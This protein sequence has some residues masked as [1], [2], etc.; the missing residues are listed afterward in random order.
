MCSKKPNLLM[1]MYSAI[2]RREAVLHILHFRKLQRSEDLN[3]KIMDFAESVPNAFESIKK[4]NL[5]REKSFPTKKY[6]ET[7]KIW[8]TLNLCVSVCLGCAHTLVAH[9]PGKVLAITEMMIKLHHYK[10]LFW[11]V[12]FHNNFMPPGNCKLGLGWVKRFEDKARVF[13]QTQLLYASHTME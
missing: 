7:N 4:T 5:K 13:Q 12:L 6:W 8:I 3:N 10:I 2:S 11:K 1:K 9:L